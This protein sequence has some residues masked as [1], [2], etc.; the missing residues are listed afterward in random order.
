MSQE[1]SSSPLPKELEYLDTATRWLD[2]KFRIPGTEI[3][4]GFD[5]LIGLVPGVGDAIS[6]ALSGSLIVVMARHGA[7]FP[8][9]VRMLFNVLLDAV[10]G[11]IP[12]AGD[13][14]DVFYKAN[15]K[16]LHLLKK[17]Y[18]SGGPKGSLFVAL[19]LLFIVLV[20]LFGMILIL[21]WKLFRFLFS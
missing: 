21:I 4:F 5:V 16:N 7:T 8:L 20:V 1:H 19:L 17:H 12:I 13:V 3:R 14:F 2:S 10:L 15:R 9:L 11:V 6:F 18:K